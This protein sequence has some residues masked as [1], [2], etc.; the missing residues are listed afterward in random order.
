MFFVPQFLFLFPGNERRVAMSASRKAEKPNGRWPKRCWKAITW[1]TAPAT[2][3]SGAPW[4]GRRA[5]RPGGEGNTFTKRTGVLIYEDRLRYDVKHVDVI[6][7]SVNWW[8]LMFLKEK[9]ICFFLHGKWKLL[10]W[11]PGQQKQI[12]DIPV[13]PNKRI[14]WFCLFLMRRLAI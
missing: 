12:A 10:S 11:F 14:I 8:V 7:H 2:I 6:I 1:R 5:G 4:S 3:R 13:C 9:P